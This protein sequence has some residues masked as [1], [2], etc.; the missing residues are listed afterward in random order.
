MLRLFLSSQSKDDILQQAV[1]EGNVTD[2]QRYHLRQHLNEEKK[3]MEL[4]Q[5]I[6]YLGGEEID[7]SFQEKRLGEIFEEE[8]ANCPKST[9]NNSC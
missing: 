2:E 3:K 8:A 1:E 5:E 9:H 7:R 4:I 6:N